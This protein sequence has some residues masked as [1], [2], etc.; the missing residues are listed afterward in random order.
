LEHA[1]QIS[2]TADAIPVPAASVDLPD[3]PFTVEAWLNARSFADRVGLVAKTEGSEFGMFVSKGQPHFSVH[4]DGAYAALTAA[5]PLPTGSWHHVAGV[6]DGKEIRLYVDG[7]L[8]GRRAASGKRTKNRLPLML[9]ADVD[10]QGRATSPFDGLLD[11]VRISTGARYQGDSFVAERRHTSDDETILLFHC[12]RP[13]S[14]WLFDASS[15][16][17]HVRRPAAARVV[18]A[19]G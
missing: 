11:E 19:N 1:L 8:V 14:P 6:F 4:V 2:G 5:A 16:G 12:D 18:P 17:A 15:R 7:Q 3:G 9:G 10:A 13:R